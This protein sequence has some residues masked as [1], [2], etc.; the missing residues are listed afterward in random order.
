[1]II[2]KIEK[3]VKHQIINNND[4]E[5]IKN[6]EKSLFEKEKTN[7]ARLQEIMNHFTRLH[8]QGKI[9]SG[10]TNVPFDG[11]NALVRIENG[12]CVDIDI[13]NNP[14]TQAGEPIHMGE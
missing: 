6:M 4:Y 10:I 11:Y 2:R 5:R 7:A 12:L 8:Q 1:M 3:Y 14:T 13:L 9:E